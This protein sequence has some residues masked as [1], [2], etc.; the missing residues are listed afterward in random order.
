MTTNEESASDVPAWRSLDR[1]VARLRRA[2]YDRYL[3]EVPA[4]A[5]RRLRR[6]CAA[7]LRRSRMNPNAKGGVRG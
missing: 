7:W 6:G 2:A 3:F 1:E 4:A 5:A